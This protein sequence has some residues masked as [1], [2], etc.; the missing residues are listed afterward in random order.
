[1]PTPLLRTLFIGGGVAALGLAEVLRRRARR[2][3]QQM[4]ARLRS[5]IMDDV[6][7]WTSEQSGEDFDLVRGRLEALETS[8]DSPPEIEGVSRI[9][10][11]WTKNSATV[12][13]RE[14]VVARV[15]D[16]AKV[17]VG[18]ITREVNW[19]DTPGDIRSS[20]IERPSEPV[21]YAMFGD[22]DAEPSESSEST[23][24]KE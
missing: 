13:S 19:C 20:F 2:Q 7:R 8:V 17:V 15:T 18:R 9:E 14:V 12:V 1:M 24:R 11:H 16:D 4:E 10:V 23:S 3:G 5:S 22:E 21:V 6:A